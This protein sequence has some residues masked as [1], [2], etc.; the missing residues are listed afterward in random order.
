MLY[1]FS[2]RIDYGATS[3]VT[4]NGVVECEERIA[5]K[6]DF[7]KVRKQVAKQ[8]LSEFPELTVS[9]ERVKFLA[10]NPL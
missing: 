9:E 1:F 6:A 5:T 7:I 2:A 10:F 4:T 8:V 3:Y